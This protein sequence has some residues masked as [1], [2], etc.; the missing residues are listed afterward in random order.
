V[1][2][3]NLDMNKMTNPV[4]PAATC[5]RKST[6]VLAALIIVSFLCLAA[7]N[8]QDAGTR[9][10]WTTTS[11]VAKPPS[12]PANL[13]AEL[14]PHALATSQ[15]MVDDYKITILDDMIPGRRTISEWGFSALIE[16]R[17]AGVYRRFLFDTGGN[18]QTVLSN[19]KTLN[20]SIC[21]IQDVILSHNHDDH[22]TGLDMLRSGC[23]DTNP[24]AFKNAYVGG[25]EIFWPRI[26]AG[27]NANYMVGEK[28]RYLAQGGS[29][30]VNSQ[31]TP[32]F[33]GLP[34]V[35]LTGKIS[36][37]HDEKTYPGT[38]NIQ[39]PAGKL[40]LDVMPEEM[41]LVINTT[42]GMVIVTGCA[43]AGITN[44]IETAQAILGAQPPV[45]VV[46]GI[47][48]FAMPLGEESTNGTEGTVIWEAHQML[49]NGVIEILGAHCTGF[50]RFTYMR[51]FLG[52]DDNSAV[53][54]SVGTVL[55]MSGGFGYTLPYAVNLPL[56]RL[57]ATPN[58]IPVTGGARYGVTTLIW[59]APGVAIVEIHVG[60]PD[61]PIFSLSG[62]NGN[63]NSGSAQTG[64]WVP[65]GAIF[66]LQDVTGGKALT[67]A[68]T[69]ASVVV[70]LK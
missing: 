6:L 38:P 5:G 61:G 54:S 48:F 57:T 8:G 22:T 30:I 55:S 49:S 39:D 21:D 16:I 24:D 14:L 42:T 41:A 69:L 27:T 40:S 52:L 46:G 44:T 31:P 17:S 65:D 62:W 63:V 53:F 15:P 56:P 67:S 12:L 58:P 37:K 20:I 29:F 9:S 4:F 43:H 50:E 11:R 59:S 66:Y 60:S 70:H 28:P 1:R 68:N 35:W 45:T 2:K 23:K 13:M 18:P 51:A 64:P 25:D 19:A 32:Q 47:H 3:R 26:S 33:L 7:A 36:R 34:G 10:A